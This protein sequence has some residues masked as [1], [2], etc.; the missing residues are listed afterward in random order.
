[1][2]ALWN[3]CA[4]SIREIQEAFPESR[5]PAYTTVQ[6]TVYRLEGKGSQPLFAEALLC[7]CC[8][9]GI[10]SVLE[11][12]GLAHP[13]TFPGVA[14]ACHEMWVLARNPRPWLSGVLPNAQRHI[15]GRPPE[16]NPRFMNEPVVIGEVRTV[17][18]AR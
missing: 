9:R 17:V 14:L 13:E 2:E 5:R 7:A 6:T 10:H 18:L 3:R 8:D 16:P 11:T 15:P 1:M 12:P 4:C